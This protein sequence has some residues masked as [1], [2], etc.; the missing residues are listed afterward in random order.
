MTDYIS[1]QLWQ[2]AIGFALIG[3][4]GFI[5]GLWA[6]TTFH[7]RRAAILSFASGAALILIGCLVATGKNIT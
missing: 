4:G 5:I 6:A 3:L 7:T 1:I 2:A